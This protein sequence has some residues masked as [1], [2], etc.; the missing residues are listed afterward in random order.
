MAAHVI[1]EVTTT[2]ES[3]EQAE[4]LSQ[5]LVEKRLAA[6]VQVSGPIPCT[7]PWHA[8]QCQSAEYRCQ[9]KTTEPGVQKLITQLE[10]LHP[11]D[12]PEILCHRAMAVNKAYGDWVA[13]NVDVPKP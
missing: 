9:M 8:K 4:H 12:T 10:Q 7:Y 2:L 13:E 11:Y 3:K 1:V 6:C 5:Q